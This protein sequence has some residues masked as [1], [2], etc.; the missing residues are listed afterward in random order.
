VSA[1]QLDEDRLGWTELLA[2][3]LVAALLGWVI[4]GPTRRGIEDVIVDTGSA[5]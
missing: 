1:V 3:L 2:A 5:P 4:L